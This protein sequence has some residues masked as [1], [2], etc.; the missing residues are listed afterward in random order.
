MCCCKHILDT[1]LWQCVALKAGV[2][3]RNDAGIRELSTLRSVRALQFLYYLPALRRLVEQGLK[4][5]THTLSALVVVIFLWF[6]FSLLA[7]QLFSQV[8]LEEIGTLLPVRRSDCPTPAF[9]D[10]LLSDI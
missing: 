8:E 10:S 1:K 6:T 3:T 2:W 5:M 9:N 4:S 7:Q